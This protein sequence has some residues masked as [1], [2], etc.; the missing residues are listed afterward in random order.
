[1]KTFKVAAAAIILVAIAASPSWG[2]G[3]VTID[4]LD[5]SEWP[6]V[7]IAVSG[8][9]SSEFAVSENGDE[10]ADVSVRSFE[11]I[12]TTIEVVLAIDTS[13]SMEG[14]PLA[15]AL[16]AARR[17]IDDVPANVSV[18]LVTFSDGARLL[19]P[20][21]T[22]RDRTRAALNGLSAVG[23]TALYDGVKESVEAFGTSDQRNI[24][25]LSD[26]A[27]TVSATSLEEALRSAKKGNA[28]VY[29][30]GLESSEADIAAL[31][32]FASKTGAEYSTADVSNLGA[33]FSGLAGTIENQYVITYRSAL[34]G[35]E[36]FTVEVASPDGT[37]QRLSLAPAVSTPESRPA[38][39]PIADP[40]V[41]S[42]T[43][44]LIVVLALC[45][46]TLS[47]IAYVLMSGSAR[48][49]RDRKLARLMAGAGQGSSS[50]EGNEEKGAAGW[51]PDPL[52]SIGEGVAARG[53]WGSSLDR[54]L[55]RAGS[56]LKAGELIAAQVVFGIA[57]A[58]VGAL[59][60]NFLLLL[61]LGIAGA[62]APRAYISMR[63]NRRF[64]AL[65]SQLP[66]ILMVLASSL[67][68]GHSFLQAL[69]AVANELPDPGGPEFA[70]V[71]AEIR[72]GRPLKDGLDDLAVR[73]GSEDFKWAMLAVNIQR[74]VGGNLAEVLD[75]VADT[76][77]GRDYVR[78]QVKV[79]S[80]EGKLSMFVL[81]A[82]P[83]AVATW[84]MLVNPSYIG[85]LVTTGLGWIMTIVSVSLLILGFFWMRKV[86]KIDV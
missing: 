61:V 20:P 82:L 81:G 22:D 16:D 17:F 43:G 10:V 47:L 38:P 73:I 69:D 37:D 77:R 9:A 59:L 39:A 5:L 40:G 50:D 24:V 35:G 72:L 25:L 75:T 44:G 65:E 15:A 14:A 54:Q 79:L 21:T 46:A 58:V 71:V 4:K 60:G 68:A 83:L 28:A 33:M 41:L 80:A 84:M 66:D 49:K 8:G 34:E 27:D 76:I 12:G 67:R 45:F 26:G 78:R 7:R 56:T 6:D 29:T 57:G 62:L 74:E 13:G 48:Q 1:M 53:D 86:V 3:K 32:Q 23:E 2:A 63:G 52:V 42:G 30:V 31:R 19:V 51:I 55:E 85:L 70:R 64:S 18:G 11:Q 36:Q